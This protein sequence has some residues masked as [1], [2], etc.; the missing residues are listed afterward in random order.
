VG[1]VGR[2]TCVCESEVRFWE[3]ARFVYKQRIRGWEELQCGKSDLRI[4]RFRNKIRS[5]RIKSM[6]TDKQTQQ[7][8]NQSFYAQSVV[9]DEPMRLAARML[10]GAQLLFQTWR[11]ELRCPRTNF[12]DGK[13]PRPISRL[14]YM[15]WIQSWK[16]CG[17]LWNLE[18]DSDGSLSPR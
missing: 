9:R 12:R 8:C 14:A 17:S 11:S 16:V 18:T 6:Y 13:V 2:L 5:M 3:C 15:G 10:L 4:S 1:S 7:R